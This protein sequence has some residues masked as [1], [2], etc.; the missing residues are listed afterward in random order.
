MLADASS[1]SQLSYFHCSERC[2]A[3]LRCGCLRLGIFSKACKG[4]ERHLYGPCTGQKDHQY[5]DV[6]RQATASAFRTRVLLDETPSGSLPNATGLVSRK[7]TPV[8]AVMARGAQ[9]L[10]VSQDSTPAAAVGAKG[11][12]R[13]AGVTRPRTLRR[14]GCV[15]KIHCKACGRVRVL[16][17]R[18]G[19]LLA[20]PVPLRAHAHP[21]QLSCGALSAHHPCHGPSAGRPEPWGEAQGEL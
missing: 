9:R 10:L 3:I 15:T 2:P 19:L 13:Q 14:C 18:A 17:C 5:T 11:A 20:R 4:R 8:A 6:N 1:Y 16:S 12:Q 7:S 21:G